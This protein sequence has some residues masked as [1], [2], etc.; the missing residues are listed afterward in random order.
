MQPNALLQQKRS[1][2]EINQLRT[3]RSLKPVAKQANQTF[4]TIR[5]KYRFDEEKWCSTQSRV[6]EL[7]REE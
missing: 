5:S 1:M 2:P 3:E 7:R 6:T 4:Q